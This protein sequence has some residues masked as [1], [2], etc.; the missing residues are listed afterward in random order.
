MLKVLKPR[1][2]PITTVRPLLIATMAVLIVSTLG[3]TALLARGR[4]G[5]TDAIFLVAAPWAFLAAAFKPDWLLIGLIAL[6]ASVTASV[7]T[8]RALLLVGV[9]LAALLITRQRVTLGFRTGLAALVIVVIAGHL[10]QASVGEDASAVNRGAMLHLTYYILLALLAFNLAVLGEL[11]GGA[12]GAALVLGVMSTLIVGLAGYE[13]AWFEGGLGIIT[14]SY[15]AY[16]AAAALGVSLARLFMAQ[17]VAGRRLGD[18][19]ITGILLALVV[20]SV[21]RAA[22]IAAAIT[23][24]LIA[25][26]TRRRA[27]VLILMAAIALALLTPTARQE[28]SRSESGN[29]VGQLRTGEI[30]TGRW[31]LWLGLWERAQPA[32]PW[33]NGFGYM[34]SLSSE[35][36]LGTSGQFGSE[37]SGVVAPHNDFVYLLVEFGIAGVLLLLLFWVQLFRARSL[38]SDSEDPLLRQSGSLLLGMIITGLMVALVDDVFAVRPFAERF[39]PVAGF[40]FGLAQVERSWRRHPGP[41]GRLPEPPALSALLPPA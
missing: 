4:L 2:L 5:V 35:D 12:L 8:S 3:V 13:N 38:V 9:A 29:I 18:F 36:L 11:H 39:F 41:P 32:L 26:R 14:H 33:G 34:W 20:L 1:R 15:L 17:D 24:A 6:P 37:E 27:Y 28:I 19:L 21:V 31:E 25:S 10:F 7:Q 23:F 22:W 40:I 30:T 16:M